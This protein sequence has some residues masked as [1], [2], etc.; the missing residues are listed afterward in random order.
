MNLNKFLAS[1]SPSIY[2]STPTLTIDCETTIPQEAGES[3]QLLLTSLLHNGEMRSV[4]QDALHF[5]PSLIDEMEGDVILVGHNIK[6][7][8]KLMAQA[9]LDLSKILVFDTQLAEKVLLG[10][11]PKFLPLDLGSVAMRRGFKGKEPVVDGAM[12]MKMCPST[13]PPSLLQRRCEYDVRV[14]EAIMQQQLEELIHEGKL[15]VLLTRCILTPVLADMEPYGLFMDKER[16]Y[17]EYNRAVAEYSELS[18]ALSDMADINWNSPQQVAGVLYD[19]FKF[20][21]LTKWKKPIRTK[22]GRMKADVD[23]ISKLIATTKR[24][25]RLKSLLV[26]QSRV[27]AQLTK[28]LNKFKECVD[29]DDLLVAEFKQHITVTHR[30]SSVGERYK[31]QLQNIARIFKPLFTV[32]H[33][34]WGYMEA[35][36]NNLE[37]R[38]AVELGDDE[39]G[40]EDIA[41]PEF[42]AHQHTA[43]TLTNAG[44]ETARQGAKQHTFKPLYGGSSGTDAEK[45]YYASFKARYKGIAAIQEVWLKEAYKN[46][47]VVL[48]W[49][50]EFFFPHTKFTNSGF[51]TDSTNICNYPVQSF[52]TA[53]I[54]PIAIVYTWH[55]MKD[56]KLQSFLVNTVH[57]SV[58]AEVHP[59]EKDIMREIICTSF[60]EMCYNYLYRVYKYKFKTPLGVGIKF[61]THWGEGDE[62]ILRSFRGLGWPCNT[63]LFKQ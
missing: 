50:M 25:T 20:K 47:S 31:A 34:G 2:L 24:Q 49:G 8:L 12:K 54:I 60:T 26:Q 52:A 19:K 46:K 22:T 45:E 14:T 39:Q 1:P 58:E 41:N 4:W 9:G 16:V 23:T 36:G 62:I 29:N 37:F 44:Q 42:D 33:E 10:N 57:D 59:E 53:D 30:L 43:N 38:I 6:F 35:D 56:L 63:L 51:Q 15:G 27:N 17:E 7:D 5:P 55:K 32:R 13:L 3:N 11:N 18:H 40:R 61:G 28:A 21:E 48:P